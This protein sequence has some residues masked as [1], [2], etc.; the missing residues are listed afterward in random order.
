MFSLVVIGG[1]FVF[2][3]LA[4]FYFLGF[5]GQRQR[6]YRALG[7]GSVFDYRDALC[8][9]AFAPREDVFAAGVQRQIYSSHSLDQYLNVL[10]CEDSPGFGARRYGLSLFVGITKNSSMAEEIVLALI[11]LGVFSLG[12]VL[13][14]KVA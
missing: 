8:P 3:T 13:E 10:R 9:H 14:R 12:R 7:H 6:F 11:G 2:V 1:Y 5:E 4:L